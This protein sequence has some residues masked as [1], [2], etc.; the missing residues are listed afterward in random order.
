[1]NPKSLL[2]LFRLAPAT[3][4]F[5]FIVSGFNH[6]LTKMNDTFRHSIVALA[7]KSPYVLYSDLHAALG[8]NS[9]N[10]LEK[11]L[12]EAINERTIEV[13]CFLIL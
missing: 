13:I 10:Q 7:E 12:I 6:L 3:L 2:Y 5:S 11:L 1:L 8:T 9:D 4:H